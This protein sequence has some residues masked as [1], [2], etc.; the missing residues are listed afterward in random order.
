MIISHSF[1]PISGKIAHKIKGGKFI[2]MKELMPDN[3]V[4]RSQW[5]DSGYS[6][7]NIKLREIEGPLLWGFYVLVF[8]AVL[9]PDKTGKEL[10][11]YGQSLIHLAQRHGGRGWQSYD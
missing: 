2:E 10:T 11:S 7:A 6:T 4:L 3:V 5:A 9:T 1:P 8:L